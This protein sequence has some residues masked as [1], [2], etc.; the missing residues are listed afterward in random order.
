MRH[1]TK[2]DKERARKMHD[3]GCIVCLEYLSV[4]TPPE[5]HHI[6]GKTKE[7]C[8]QKTIPLCFNHHRNK[9]NNGEWTSLHG[10]G[11]KAFEDSYGT[12]EHLLTLTNEAINND[13]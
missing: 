11:R 9:S 3:L 1:I 5:I 4:F 6:D 7:G 2:K 12:Q 8:H 13:S 10:D